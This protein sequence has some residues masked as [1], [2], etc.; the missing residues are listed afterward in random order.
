MEG[1]WRNLAHWLTELDQISA[2]FGRIWP[3]STHAKL[4]P[5]NFEPPSTRFGAKDGL[6]CADVDQTLAEID[7]HLAEP[8]HTRAE[9]DQGSLTGETCG[10]RPTAKPAHLWSSEAAL[11]PIR[12]RCLVQLVDPRPRLV[13]PSHFGSTRARI[14]VDPSAFLSN[15]D[16][17][18][19]V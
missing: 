9:S 15:Q 1:V 13:K 14:G 10:K 19:S 7:Q 17:P 5:T 6:P 8:D 4:M 18:E 12:A 2:E 3:A 11:G 16:E